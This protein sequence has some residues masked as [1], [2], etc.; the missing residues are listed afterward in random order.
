[1]AYSMELWP[2]SCMMITFAGRSR[3]DARSDCHGTSNASECE[4]TRTGRI[5]RV[6]AGRLA[7]QP[8]IQAHIVNDERFEKN[9]GDDS[10]EAT[11]FRADVVVCRSALRGLNEKM[12]C[13]RSRLRRGAFGAYKAKRSMRSRMTGRSFGSL[14][15][16]PS[17]FSRIA[18]LAFCTT[19]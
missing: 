4:V 6:T 19:L 10:R 9:R 12:N 1:M 16:R 15:A 17:N 5:R 11:S 14:T 7:A 8:F 3:W 2:R 18:R 13:E